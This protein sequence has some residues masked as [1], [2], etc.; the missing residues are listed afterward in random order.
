MGFWFVKKSKKTKA[1]NKESLKKS[2]K[3]KINKKAKR[4]TTLSSPAT[5]PENSLMMESEHIV[6]S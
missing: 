4:P 2:S 1:A 3:T 6:Y 5:S